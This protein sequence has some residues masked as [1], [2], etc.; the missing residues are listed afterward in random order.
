VSKQ[1]QNDEGRPG[2]T[3]DEAVKDPRAGLGR[4]QKMRRLALACL[5]V[6]GFAALSVVGTSWRGTAIDTLVMIVGAT[7]VWLG[8]LGRLWCSLYIGGRKSADL[9]RHGPYSMTRNPLY[10]FSAV[11]A[12]GAGALSGSILIGIAFAL[13][14][15]LAFQVVIL[16]EEKVLAELFGASFDDYRSR[17]PRYIPDPRLF[18]DAV[19]VEV[20]LRPLYRTF[21]D[22]LVFFAAWPVF[23]ILRELQSSAVL[24]VLV[25]LW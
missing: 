19:T 6:A 4:Y 20:R 11:A 21:L 10:V 8:V 14:T 17:V 7:L 25:H 9:V 13:A 2:Y 24:P 15:A 1:P 12:G 22:G 3:M 23:M 16:R 18:E 5:I